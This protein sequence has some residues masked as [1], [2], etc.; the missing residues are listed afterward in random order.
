VV[1]DGRVS[2]RVAFGG[3]SVALAELDRSLPADWLTIGDGVAT[4]SATV[5]LTRGTKFDIA[6]GE[7]RTVAL[8][9][10]AT[11][12]DAASI[13]TGGG[14]LTLT[15]V[16]VTSVDPATGQPVP[17][18]AASRPSIVASSGGR[19]EGTDLTVSDLGTP[20]VGEDDGRAAV[21]FNPGSTGFLTRTTLLRGSTGIELLR[22][23]GVR[24][25]DIAISESS[26]DGLV[27]SGDRRTTLSGIQAERNVGTVCWSP[28]RARTARSPASP[29]RAT[30]ST[31]SRS[32]SRPGPVSPPSPP[33]VTEPEGSR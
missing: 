20:P 22:S 28:A 10:G 14:A 13:H 18:I 4:L 21:V 15:G 33:A 19:L 25:A 23:E 27:L 9:G 8:A 11:S 7:V 29:R 30:A 12:A 16:A 1:V 6:G 2:R 31:A 26:A 17:A 5:V 24:L 3:T 32:T